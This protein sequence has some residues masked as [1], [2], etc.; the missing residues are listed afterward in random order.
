MPFQHHILDHAGDVLE[1]VYKRQVKVVEPGQHKGRGRLHSL[2][3]QSRRLRRFAAPRLLQ[4]LRVTLEHHERI[5]LGRAQT[6]VCGDRRRQMRQ[7]L[8][9][10]HI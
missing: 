8:S 6:G 2:G 9:L 4:K 10:I 3:K 7:R 5:A 1:D